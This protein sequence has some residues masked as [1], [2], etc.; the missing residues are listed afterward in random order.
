VIPEV[1]ADSVETIGAIVDDV[2]AVVDAVS[3]DSAVIV[4]LK[5][6]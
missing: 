1:P 2:E 6:H 4:L 5:G 3:A